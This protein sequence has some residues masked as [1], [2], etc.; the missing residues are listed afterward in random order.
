MWSIYL[1]SAGSDASG[2]K[3][4]LELLQSWLFNRVD[5]CGDVVQLAQG[6]LCVN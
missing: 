2:R 5:V 3:Q 4:T 6:L 1:Y